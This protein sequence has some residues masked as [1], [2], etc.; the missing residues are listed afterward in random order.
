MIATVGKHERVSLTKF[1]IN[2]ATF[3]RDNIMYHSSD[4]LQY[5]ETALRSSTDDEGCPLDR[6]YSVDDID[7]ASLDEMQNDLH[8]FMNKADEMCYGIEDVAANSSQFAHDFWLTRNGHGVG[9]WD[10][11]ELYSS[12]ELADKLSNL[13]RSFGPCDLYIGDDGKIYSFVG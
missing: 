9:F 3:L 5:I 10:R 1:A 2:L 8:A 12:K 4:F 6:N 11:P 13:A 7:S